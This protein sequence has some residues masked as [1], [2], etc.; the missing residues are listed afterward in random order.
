[1]ISSICNKKKKKLK[2]KNKKIKTQSGQQYWKRP[3]TA[4][5]VLKA[6]RPLKVRGKEW[7]VREK[8][9]NFGFLKQI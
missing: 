4:K 2:L 7:R 5:H 8:E 6:K 9:I 1:M 3:Y